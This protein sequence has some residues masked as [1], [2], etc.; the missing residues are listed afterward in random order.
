[1][2]QVLIRRL[3]DETLA[4][5]RLAAQHHGRSLEAELRDAIERGRP[6]RPKDPAALGEL[7]RRLR[8]Q[9]PPEAAAVDSTP[10]LRWLRDTNGGKFDGSDHP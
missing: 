6:M 5:Y 7:S 10:Y 1:M 8:A 9:T 3:S 4:D 2:G